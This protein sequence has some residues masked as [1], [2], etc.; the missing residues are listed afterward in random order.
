MSPAYEAETINI[1]LRT[2]ADPANFRI[3]IWATVVSG[4]TPVHAECGA[5]RSIAADG[6]NRINVISV[7]DIETS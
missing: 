7:C 3:F 2:D 1:R 6:R 5:D 4:G